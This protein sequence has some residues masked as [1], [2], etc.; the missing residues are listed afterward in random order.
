[1]SA[2]KGAASA[3]FTD[4]ESLRKRLTDHLDSTG[5]SQAKFAQQAGYSPASIST[6]LAGNYNSKSQAL[7]AAIEDVLDR[8]AAR[9]EVV[10]PAASGFVQT[11]ISRR[12]IALLERCHRDREM[13]LI[14]G[15]A[16]LGKTTAIEEYCEKYPSAVRVRA[17]QTAGRPL[18]FL[19][20]IAKALGNFRLPTGLDDALWAVVDVLSGS[21][22]IIIIDEA[23]K[24]SPKTLEIVRD[25]H[26]VCGV[27][28]VLAG[29]DHV[30]GMVYGTGQAA[31]SQH[32]S[33]LSGHAALSCEMLSEADVEALAGSALDPRDADS[34]G[35][36][37]S[38][39]RQ[40]GGLR[41]MLKTLALAVEMASGPSKHKFIDLLRHAHR[42]RF[43]S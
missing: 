43:S 35:Y 3:A 11:T 30:Q 36:L 24:L 16:G 5:L 18:F 33:R 19:R 26:D 29:N 37:L 31:F 7:G 20:L 13:G 2:V 41:S 21:D 17:M 38:L 22:R 34:R 25:L 28:I 32:F 6:F 42:L 39:A 1:M 10:R 40:R 4:F 8:E 9:A 12:V 23:Q 14:T 15:E 27:G